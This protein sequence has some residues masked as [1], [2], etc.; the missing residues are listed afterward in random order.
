M[1]DHQRRHR[2][3]GGGFGED[4]ISGLPDA[5]LHEILV[6]LRSASAAARTSVLS[7]RWRHLWA[8][9]PELRLVA[10]PSREAAP[11][12]FI[13]TVDA[14]LGGYLAPT[15]EHLGVSHHVTD[16]QGRDLRISPARI[17]PWLHFAAA[18]VVGELNLYLRVPQTFGASTPEI[19]WDE[20]A[21]VL[22][23]PVCERTKRIEL[24]LQYAYTH[25]LRPQASGLFA[26]LTFLK[27]N[28]YVRMEGRDL[29]ALV[30]TQCPCLRDL[31]LFIKLIDNFD[32]LIHSNSLHTLVLRVLETR[33][34]EVVA[35]RLEEFTIY[36]QP[37][38]AHISAPKLA[39]VAWHAAYD[40]HI[41]RFVDVGR[42]LQL[43]RTSK[44]AS[45][46]TK[47]FNEVDELDLNI[48]MYFPDVATYE[49]F[50]IQ[51]NK[52][53][54]CKS[55]RLLLSWE[56]HALVPIVLHLLRTE[57]CFAQK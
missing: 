31:D 54:K 49:S 5:L 10:L 33:R 4:R 2:G 57:K 25:W 28:G 46:L 27:I 12:S 7:R 29:T 9:L 3:G 35:P 43:L 39:K 56:H 52:L 19:V 20:E 13:D 36:D 30:S 38:E 6:R 47:R 23:L 45:S 1:G 18:H 40:P 14:A 48:S 24:F 16:I 15:L 11:A 21:A 51:T 42:T 32:V 34:L 8:H 26:V 37:K 44:Q 55:F 50:L 17:A 22:E 53:P 41:N